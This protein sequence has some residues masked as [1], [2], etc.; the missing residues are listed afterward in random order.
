MLTFLL[1][2][3]LNFNKYFFLNNISILDQVKLFSNAEVIVSPSGSSLTNIVFCNPGTNIIE[4]KP[5][6]KFTYENNLKSRYSDIC[7]L[8]NL[9]YISIEADPVSIENIKHS[10]K[11][12]ISPKLK[13]E[14]KI[15][16]KLKFIYQFLRTIF[17]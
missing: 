14:N 2:Y 10:K 6:Y 12:F 7:S 11:E 13:I 1:K 5:R 8:L 16:N 9:N 17:L 3:L 15:K 4:I